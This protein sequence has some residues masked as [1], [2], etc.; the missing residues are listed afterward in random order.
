MNIIFFRRK[1]IKNKIK[2]YN[3][4][5]VITIIYNAVS[6]N[7]IAYL[8]YPYPLI[9]IIRYRNKALPAFVMIYS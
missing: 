1:L 4:N 7:L 6:N 9:A 2:N 8:K 5:N 3:I